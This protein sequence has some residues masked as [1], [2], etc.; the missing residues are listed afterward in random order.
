MAVIVRETRTIAG[1]EFPT[2][3]VYKTAEGVP[4][5]REERERAERLDA[6]LAKQMKEVAAEV[7][8]LGLLDLKNRPGVVKLWYGVGRRLSFIDDNDLVPLRDRRFVWRALYDHADDL[9]P[10]PPG[11]RANQRPE[12]SHFRY[13]YLLAKFDEDVALSASWTFWV[14]CFD[15]IAIRED[16]RIVEWLASSIREIGLKQNE[17][18]ALNKAIRAEFREVDTT[19]LSDEELTQR[20]ASCLSA[21]RAHQDRNEP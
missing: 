18:R 9:L 14:E 19:V 10:G 6:L 5:T 16:E 1:R 17:I 21:S 8:S 2:V 15:S 12:N 11:I 4:L 13:C 3:K 20:L 7:R